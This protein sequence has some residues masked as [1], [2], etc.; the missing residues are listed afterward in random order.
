MGCKWISQCLFLKAECPLWL[1]LVILLSPFLPTAK[2]VTELKELN[3]S[4]RFRETFLP[5]GQPLL[6]GMLMKRPDLAN[7]LDLVG[8]EGASAFYSG[9]LTQEIISEVSCVCA[10]LP[11]DCCL[12][13]LR[14]SNGAI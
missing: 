2:A 6:A 14:P 4:D 10:G 9:N 11:L 7:T 8:A 12:V 1:P 5:E 13:H 3:Y